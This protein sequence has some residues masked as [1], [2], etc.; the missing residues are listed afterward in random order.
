MEKTQASS[1]PF[2]AS[3]IEW[4]NKV[5]RDLSTRTELII[6]AMLFFLCFVNLAIIAYAFNQFQV[7]IAAALV[8][9]ISTAVTQG[10]AGLLNSSSTGATISSD[11]D[12][13]RNTYLTIVVSVSLMMTLLFGYLVARMALAPTRS[14]LES[15]KQFIGNVA[16]ELR[17][18]LS[19]IKANSEIMLLE[20]GGKNSA[21]LTKSNIEEL[22]N[23]SGIINNLLTLNAFR[24]VQHMNFQ[25]VA[26][27]D[28][29]RDTLRQLEQLAHNKQ[30]Q[31]DLT[32]SDTLLVWG[33]KSGLAQISM[34][35]IRNAIVYT[36][37]DG[38]VRI[39]T[40]NASR[41]TVALEVTDTGIGIEPE[42][43][44][45]IF[46]PFYRVDPARSKTAGSSGL[47]LAIVSEL[48]KFHHGKIS[49]ESTPHVGTTV[50]VEFPSRGNADPNLPSHPTNGTARGEIV[51]DFSRH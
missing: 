33:N 21:A 47:G 43:L 31:L 17:T 40:A 2:A 28:V 50:R 20:P 4:V 15:Q 51:M 38:T 1:K 27:G 18:P 7:D 34:N 10:R 6:I 41:N 45:R 32:A 44:R 48:V 26:L 35:L 13:L 25:W 8:E 11:L 37:Q 30:I 9:T 39:T 49:I 36:P 12:T 19:I 5:R 22:D 42:K 24:N 16:H 46:E 3:G 29:V 14:A 23:I